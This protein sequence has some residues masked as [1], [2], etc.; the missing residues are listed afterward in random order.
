MSLVFIS[1]KVQILNIAEN[2]YIQISLKELV[3][4]IIAIHFG[5]LR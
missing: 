1:F 4:Q 5:L 2:V 3:G